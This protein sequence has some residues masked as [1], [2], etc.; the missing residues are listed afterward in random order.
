MIEL[1]EEQEREIKDYVCEEVR[2]AEEERDEK[3]KMWQKWRRQREARPEHEVKTY[4]FRSGSSNVAVPLSAVNATTTFGHL[5]STFNTKRPFWTITALRDDEVDRELAEVGTKYMQILAKSKHDVNLPKVRR[6]ILY[7]DGTMGLCPVKVPWTER[8]WHFKYTDESGEDVVVDATM[9]DG[10]ELIPVPL[11][12]FLYREAYQDIQTAPWLAHVVHKPWHI[13]KNEGEQGLYENVDEIKEHARMFPHEY[14]EADDRRRGAEREIS[15]MYDVHEVWMFYDVDEDG[16]FE[17]IVVT[18]HVKSKTILGVK[19][20]ELGWR[21]FEPFIHLIRPYYIDGIGTCWMSEQM[22]DEVDMWHNLRNDSAKISTVPMFA[23]RRNAGVKPNEQAYPGKLWFV[24]DPKS[25]IVPM[26]SVDSYPSSLEAENMAVMYSQKATAMPDVMGG[27]AN[28]TIKTRDSV[29]LAKTRLGQSRGVFGSI[30]EGVAESFSQVGFLVFLQLAKN[31][32]RVIE[33][34][35]KAKRLTEDEIRKLDRLLSIKFEDIPVRMGF[36][37]KT[38]DIEKTF[39]TKRQNYLTLSQLYT[40]YLEK[41]SPVAMQLF[42]PESQQM[43]QQ[44]PEMYDYLVQVFKGSSRFMEKIMEF[45]GEE[46]TEEYLPDYERLQMLQD[47]KDSLQGEVRRL[48]NVNTGRM[49]QNAGGA[50]GG[51]GQGPTG[52]EGM[53]GGFAEQPGVPGG[54]GDMEQF[55]GPVR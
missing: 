54:A 32:E 27:F 36:S 41:I 46:D 31:R 6:V 8:K 47:F 17:D 39:E 7:E 28:E 11:E 16:Q 18:M 14:E 50:A 51:G 13:I 15:P 1:S 2:L 19:Y 48:G 24:D 34:E 43:R 22:Q 5:I 3:M 25:D 38:T 45:F 30:T 53:A 4:P 52:A 29:G 33:N 49:G 23:V 44:A 42:S 37:V 55:T 9:H 21:P 35:V 40:Q 20:N 26:R 10:P 12:D